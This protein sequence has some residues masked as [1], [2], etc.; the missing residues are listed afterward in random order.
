MRI[1]WISMAAAAGLF[2]AVA[3]LIIFS[4]RQDL[5]SNDTIFEY[6]HDWEYRFDGQEGV[7]DL[8]CN[9]KA[10]E[11]VEMTLTNRLPT[12]LADDSVL[13]FRSRMERVRVYVGDRLVYQYPDRELIGRE[14]PS[15]WNF[16]ELSKEDAG[17]RIR[18]C[19][20]SAY[21]RFSGTMSSVRIGNYKDLTATVISEQIKVFR[22]SLMVGLV[23]LA[24][25]VISFISRKKKIL[26]WQSSLGLLL[27][28]L[29]CWLCGESRMPSGYV[30][31]EAWHYMAFLSL[32]LCPVFLTS[33]LYARWKDIHGEKT[34]ILFYTCLTIA[35][36]IVLSELLGG[37]D[38]VQLLPVTQFMVAV[39]LVY[40]LWIYCLAARRKKE[41][42]IDSELVCVI[43]TVLAGLTGIVRFYRTDQIFSFY[44]RLAILLYALNILRISVVILLRKIRENQELER[45]LRRSRAE[46]MASQIKPHFI[47]N[48]LNSI[49][50]LISLNPEMAKKMVYDFTTY[51]RSN[52]DNVGDRDMIPF[53]DELRHIQAYLNIEKVRFEE[54]LNIV[55][56]IRTRGFQVPPLSIQP[57]VENAVKHGI[58]KKVDGGTVT[59]RT[60]EEKDAYVVKVEDDGAGFDMA[61][62]EEKTKDQREEGHLGLE[63]IRFR[64]Q[65]IA[66]GTLDVESVPGRG[67][68]VTV[69]FR[70]GKS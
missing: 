42:R 9:K 12:N 31:V 25:F 26:E 43:I 28:V 44:I 34:K 33:Y 20:E 57:L 16:V 67:T 21:G 15:V 6:N 60:Y 40:A 45:E 55:V 58:C 39:T 64:V 30:G 7:T 27:M 46:L 70:K 49:R 4:H 18:I 13:V 69:T 5:Y 14:I 59:L 3:Y 48:T 8:P 62:L 54:R 29:S 2:L 19:L 68:K 10:P 17:K 24:I 41:R 47:Y 63:N 35:A 32:P 53:S 65:E 52:L 61:L 56:D 1:K 37:P 36:G 51:L 22:M 23:G 38:L 50:T 11:N 66:G